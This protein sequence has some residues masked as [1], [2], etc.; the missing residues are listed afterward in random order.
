[1]PS[2]RPS[3]VATTQTASINRPAHRLRLITGTAL[4][5]WSWA[6]MRLILARATAVSTI[7]IAACSA[8]AAATNRFHLWPSHGPGISPSDGERS[9]TNAPTIQMAISLWPSSLG[10]PRSVH[11]VRSSFGASASRDISASVSPTEIKLVPTNNNLIVFICSLSNG[12][13]QEMPRQTV[14][15]VL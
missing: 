2:R 3:Q 15:P 9:N 7:P 1:M 11:F 14:D 5:H 13:A 10:S 8:V 6:A 4:V 12:R